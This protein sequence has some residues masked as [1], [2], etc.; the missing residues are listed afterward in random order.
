MKEKEEAEKRV[1]K[2]RQAEHLIRQEDERQQERE[3]PQDKQHG[4]TEAEKHH[5]RQ[6]QTEHLLHQVE[7]QHKETKDAAKIQDKQQQQHQ[8]EEDDQQI[9]GGVKSNRKMKTQRSPKAAR[10]SLKAADYQQFLEKSQ[11]DKNKRTEDAMRS[12]RLK[13]NETR[14]GFFLSCMLLQLTSLSV[15]GLKWKQL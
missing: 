5:L 4:E 1:L 15:K 7:K 13:N 10:Q 12:A 2:K 9:P 3:P 6:S 11:K 14:R 8:G